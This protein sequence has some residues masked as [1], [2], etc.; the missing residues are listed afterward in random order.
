MTYSQIVAANVRAELARRNLRTR[1]LAPVLDL[2]T[3][4]VRARLV[5]E[6]EMT[7]TEVGK[8]A[9]FLKIP[10]EFLVNPTPDQSVSFAA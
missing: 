4:A 1:D 3:T 10:Y 2:K 6:V 8:I 5:G 7:F 9:E